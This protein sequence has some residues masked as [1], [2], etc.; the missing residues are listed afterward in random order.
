MV[1]KRDMRMHFNEI[2]FRTWSCPSGSSFLQS[3]F[4]LITVMKCNHVHVS[5]VSYTWWWNLIL[6]VLSFMQWYFQYSPQYLAYLGYFENGI[7]YQG[8]RQLMIVGN[9]PLGSFSKICISILYSFVSLSYKKVKIVAHLL[10][11]CRN[12]KFK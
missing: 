2:E 1:L 3:Q 4:V 10:Y 9:Y 7:Q 5:N 11:H 6:I 8:R 12:L